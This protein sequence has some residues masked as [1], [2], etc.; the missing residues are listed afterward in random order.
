MPPDDEGWSWYAAYSTAEA[1]AEGLLRADD[2]FTYW[3]AIEGG[4]I[5]VWRRP[6]QDGD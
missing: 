5:K 6:R 1:A 4:R 2:G 3:V